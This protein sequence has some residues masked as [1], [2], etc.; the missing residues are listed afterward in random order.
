MTFTLIQPTISRAHFPS[1]IHCP[2]GLPWSF[3]A[4]VDHLNKICAL[5][6]DHH[7]TSTSDSSGMHIE[8]PDA[9]Q[10]CN[11]RIHGGTP[12]LEDVPAYLRAGPSIR[13]HYSVLVWAFRTWGSRW[14]RMDGYRSWGVWFGFSVSCKDNCQCNDDCYKN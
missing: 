12:F 5:L 3:L 11:R 1:D 9:K 4:K 6:I 2:V 7:K 10:G 14:W 13:G 8:N